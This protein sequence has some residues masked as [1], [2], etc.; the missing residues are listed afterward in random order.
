MLLCRA[1]TVLGMLG[2]LALGNC[3]ASICSF[4][5][6]T[7][8]QGPQSPETNLPDPTGTMPVEVWLFFLHLLLR[9]SCLPFIVPLIQTCCDLHSQQ[10]C[11][12][13]N[14]HSWVSSSHSSYPRYCPFTW[15]N[16]DYKIKRWSTHKNL[17]SHF[18]VVSS[19]MQKRL[20]MPDLELRTL[21]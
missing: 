10:R 3:S 2:T 11:L 7:L 8:T 15:L 4:V 12:A 18:I 9:L 19:T 5:R 6:R 13:Q 16:D 14:S 20:V 21:N 1:Y 17:S